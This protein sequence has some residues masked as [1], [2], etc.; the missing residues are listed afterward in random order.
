LQFISH[1]E[2]RTRYAKKYFVNGDSTFQFIHD[3]F[4]K[5]HLGNVRMVLT[6]ELVQA[7]YPAATL[8]G[9]TASSTDAVAVEKQYYD[10]QPANIADR[11][12]A[13][14]ITDYQNNNGIPNNNP[15]SNATALSKKL[16]RLKATSAVNGGVTGLGITLK[17]SSG[18][19]I[20]ILA[21]S[22]YFDNNTG[23]NYSIPSEAILTGLFGIPG[24]TGGSKVLAAANANGRRA[25]GELVNAWLKD[26]K[27]NNDKPDNKPRAYIN[28]ILFDNNFKFV[29]G[30]FDRVGERNKVKRHALTDIPVTQ[31]GYLYVYAS[32]ESPVNVFFDNL[33]VTQTQGHILEE[34]HYYPFG[35][36]MAGISS[37]ALKNQY[38][39]NKYQYNGKEKQSKEFYDGSGLVEWYDF[40]ARMYDPQ[41]GRFISNDRVGELAHNLTGYRFGFNNP[42]LYN[43]P[44]GLWEGTY[45]RGDA[46]FEQ[47]LSSLQNGTFN[48]DDGENDKDKDK[49]NKKSNSSTAA[50]IAF[51]KNF[52]KKPT[53]YKEDFNR[54]VGYAVDLM[55][56]ASDDPDF[57]ENS[58]LYSGQFYAA[59]LPI[60]DEALVEQGFMYTFGELLGAV[61][62][63]AGSGGVTKKFLNF[64]RT[65]SN[66][67]DEAGRRIPIEIIKQV[68][69][70]P[71]TVV[72]DPRGTSA[73]M[74]FSQL[75]R[76]GELYNVEVLYD[77]ASNTVMH[78]K[79]SRAPMGP[80]PKIPKPTTSN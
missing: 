66:H 47:L 72:S 73:H 61:F 8:E 64:T 27:R 11:S 54:R 29:S 15:N 45:R 62:K 9:S 22:Y 51:Y 4:V 75:W 3:Y 76:N 1:E 78:F 20:N 25:A 79:Y 80:L 26:P 31:N 67:L 48:I 23:G 74:Y 57:Y 69:E 17:V 41:I 63:F 37:K 16:Y 28:W 34:T 58:A 46:G 19:K 60:L 2:G 43:D 38:A 56:R 55:Q 35:L 53:S 77:R 52:A 42:I 7:V 65:A 14:G 33:Q 70:T 32:N 39:E 44:S 49:D 18:D 50:Q 21:N 6:E 5:D 24:S 12:M 40:N 36:T 30:S 71:M 10:I 59:T 13:T 68:I